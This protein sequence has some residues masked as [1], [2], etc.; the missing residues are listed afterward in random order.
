MNRNSNPVRLLVGDI[1]KESRESTGLSQEKISLDLGFSDRA[2]YYY[3]KGLRRMDVPLIQRFAKVF[4]WDKTTY[5][6]VLF[7]MAVSE[8]YT[9]EE[10]IEQFNVID[11]SGYYDYH[12][13]S[14]DEIDY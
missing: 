6:K 7:F 10:A 1:V 11:S 9:P 13:G 2:L 12:D 3:E 14:Y 8:H 5:Y 4:N